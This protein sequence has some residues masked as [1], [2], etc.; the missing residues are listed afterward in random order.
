MRSFPLLL[1]ATIFANAN[2]DMGKAVA[3]GASSGLDAIGG[4]LFLGIIIAI[5]FALITRGRKM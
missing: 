4:W 5:I 1:L 3:E 2:V